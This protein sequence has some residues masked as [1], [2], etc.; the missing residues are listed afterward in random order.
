[1]IDRINT[2]NGDYCFTVDVKAM[3]SIQPEDKEYAKFVAMRAMMD[4]RP[5]YMGQR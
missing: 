1:M 2:A 4:I 3:E 5:I